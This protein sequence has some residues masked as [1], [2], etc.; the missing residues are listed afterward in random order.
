MN[1]YSCAFHT[2]AAHDSRGQ[3]RGFI[4]CVATAPLQIRGSNPGHFV[5]GLHQ[6]IGSGG[7]TR[8][9]QTQLAEPC[10]GSIPQQMLRNLELRGFWSMATFLSFNVF[11]RSIFSEFNDV[12]LRSR[13]SAAQAEEASFL[14]P[15]Q[16]G[17]NVP[18]GRN[19]KRGCTWVAELEPLVVSCGSASLGVFLQIS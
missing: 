8:P 5:V 14:V 12:T 11:G 16:W 7:C 13:H 2:P 15:N 3:G 19:P 10:P 6:F 1:P 18:V 4:P 17:L 9:G